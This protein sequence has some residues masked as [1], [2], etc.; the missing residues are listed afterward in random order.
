MTEHGRQTDAISQWGSEQLALLGYVL[1]NEV[2]QLVLDTPWSYVVRFETTQG[3]IYLKH[4]P[5]QLS[6]EASIIKLL[7]DKFDA[8]A[9]AVIAHNEQLHCFL[10]LDAGS[11]LRM[12]L[13]NK[14]DMAL[15]CEAI[16]QFTEMQSAVADQVECLLDLGVPDWRLER[17]PELYKQLLDETDILKADGLS[18]KDIIQLQALSPV[19]CS[20]CEKL[21][22]YSIKQTL[23]QSDFHDNNVLIDPETK[24]ITFIDLGEI[25]ISHPFFSLIGCLHQA[26]KHHGLTDQDESCARLLEAGLKGYAQVETPQRLQEAMGLAQ[27]LWILHEALAQY[28]LRM[29]C[30]EAYFLQFQRHGRLSGSLKEFMRALV[31]SC[32]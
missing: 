19:V 24:K 5:E 25:V 20:L 28:R 6:L 22:G 18:E 8:R 16:E 3:L 11:P 26:Q 4:T 31:A 9:P 32:D 13:K 17:F 15:Y 30:D 14:F 7:T 29:A 10:M 12:L 27:V 23:V 1:K 2:P 21:S